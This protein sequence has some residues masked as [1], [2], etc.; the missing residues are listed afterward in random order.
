M[1]AP[2]RLAECIDAYLFKL[3]SSG[4]P[5]RKALA[6]LVEVAWLAS[7]KTEEG[8]PTVCNLAYID[9]HNPD[10][11]PP[12]LI[13]LPRWSYYAINDPVPLTVGNLAKLA[14]ALNPYTAN[15]AFF[16]LPARGLFISGFTDQQ[17]LFR[18]G[19]EFE[20]DGGWAR[21]GLFQLDILGIGSLAAYDSD[22][23]IASVR[24]ET[25][26]TNT[27]DVF[28]SG[29]IAEKLRA[30]L[31]YPIVDEGLSFDT[32]M[33]CLCRILIRMRRFR[34]GGALLFDNPPAKSRLRLKH[35]VKYTKLRAAIALYFEAQAAYLDVP[36]DND[37]EPI[38]VQYD[39]LLEQTIA[40]ENI[41]DARVAMLGAVGLIASLSR[42]D[43]LVLLG[44]QFELN[45]FGGEIIAKNDPPVVV[46]SRT[47]QVPKASAKSVSISDFGTRHRSMFRYC[48]A[49]PN[50]VGIVVSQDGDVRVITRDAD[51][52]VL[53]ENVRVDRSKPVARVHRRP[54]RVGP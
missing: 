36:F 49:S 9:P 54:K 31:G 28:S 6:K 45:G 33:R 43:G 32:A 22:K 10:P 3:G 7:L 14:P 38:D 5:S 47:S 17:T 15:I 8:R 19:F 48:W 4:R 37:E 34:H 51:R 41:E 42:I 13:R 26:V 39:N 11:N 53:W 46:I 50:C 21:P 27:A 16:D 44:N 12:P 24:H 52:I 18:Q 29:L 25:L 40:L 30:I 23:L 35:S 20:E 2:I 1:A